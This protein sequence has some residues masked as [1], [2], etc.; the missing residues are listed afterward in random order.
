MQNKGENLTVRLSP[1][2][3]IPDNDH[4][5][6]EHL[7]TG[8]FYE[9]PRP[10][11]EAMEA[12]VKGIPPD[13]IEIELINKY[14]DEEINM[15]DFLAQLKDMGFLIDNEKNDFVNGN[16]IDQNLDSEASMI[17]NSIIGQFL[18]RKQAIPVYAILFCVNIVYFISRPDLFPHPRDLFPFESMMLN[19]IVSLV[20]S[21]TFLAIHECGHVIA[22]RTYGLITSIRLGHRLFL[23]VVETQMPTIWR[24][25]RGRRNV[26][27]LAGL[28]MDHTLLFV[29]LSVLVFVSSLS[30]TISGILGLIVFQ[31]VMMSLYQ[32]MFFMKTDLY[33]ILQNVSGSYN[34]L[35]NAESWLKEKLP[36]IRLDNTSVI[37][38]KERNIVRG[39]AVFYVI[40][41]LA[42][43]AVFVLY[44]IP[45]LMYSFAISLD[46]LINPSTNP[47]KAD[48][49]LFFAQFA[50]FA[51]LLIFSWTKK[52]TR[53]RQ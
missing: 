11:V 21:V 35:E 12:L 31:L 16:E 37:Y 30:V 50:V 10:A 42:S 1:Q 6:V 32:C 25:P 19:I 39:Y 26:P 41:L 48:A 2:R 46:R 23:P 27:L 9:M 43:G 53:V 14:P 7:Q 13:Q 28:F 29:S 49:I 51:G 34:L 8:E 36:F 52:F 15:M 5:I 22:A 3:I 20:V 24:L 33:Y 4:Y 40:G 18:F 45:Q 38:D 17:S 44:I 47:M